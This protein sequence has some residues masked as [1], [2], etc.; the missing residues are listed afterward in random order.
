MNP[1]IYVVIVNYNNID[2][3]V[4]TVNS[5]KRQSYFPL[6]I[7]VVDNGS[8]PEIL[9]K[10]R[11]IEDI[12]II[13]NKSNLGWAAATN[14]G[15]QYALAQ[16]AEYV[17][18]AN[19]DIFIDDYTLIN[20]LLNNFKQFG[21]KSKVNILGTR[22]NDYNNINYTHN[23][24]KI[25]FEG[26][27]KGPKKFN[28]YRV[29]YIQNNSLPEPFKIVDFVEGCFMMINCKLFGKIGFFKEEFFM[30]YD[31]AEF[32]Y[33]AWQKGYPA[34]V[35]KSLVV[36]HKISKT[37]G[38]KT[39][40]QVYYLTRNEFLFFKLYKK[41]FTTYFKLALTFQNMVTIRNI[42]FFKRKKQYSGSK[43]ELL[44]ALIWAYI[45]AAKNK[46]PKRY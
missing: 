19:N 42:L 2:D 44:K 13:V 16:K 21:S 8:K 46:T 28:R 24:G 12:T 1:L 45:D 22:I 27:E 5:F 15:I 31:E 43:L 9:E 38:E 36:Y 29:S 3:L 39:P 6:K 37:A 32:C 40:F 23:S 10:I 4:I 14:K 17:A 25:F 18:L 20:V 34:I 35:N 11:G 41:M 7:L 33:R 30:Y 26:F